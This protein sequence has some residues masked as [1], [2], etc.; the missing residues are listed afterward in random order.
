MAQLDV[1]S[2]SVKFGGNLALDS[3]TLS[4]RDNHITGLIGP[5]GAGKT[6][7]F[8]AITGMVK[9]TSGSVSLEG[10]D[11]SSLRTHKRARLGIARTFQ[12]LESWNQLTVREAIEVAGDI[13]HRN[14]GP[15][16]T[17]ENVEA[18]AEMV[19]LLG[20]IE[21]RCESLSTGQSRQ[22]EIA[23]T[24]ATLPATM[25]LDEPA[26]GLDDTETQKFADLLKGLRN[27]NL[28]I[29]LVEHDVELVMDVCD[30]I[31]VLDFG[32]VIASGSPEE[33]KQNKAVLDA[34]LG[35]PE[36]SQ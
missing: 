36:E 24:L 23:R 3:V 8:N 5:N 27:E 22:V 26:S 34:Y 18:T 2:V 29:L 31:Y 17:D 1:D 20:Q 7:L 21:A 9:P 32:Q 14:G 4:A 11:I 10:K 35:A 19:G 12:R 28:A 33:V 13:K 30:Q 15:P 16:V 25:L 6:T